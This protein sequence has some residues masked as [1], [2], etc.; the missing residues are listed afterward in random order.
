M[1]FR[2][3]A[4]DTELKKKK[5]KASQRRKPAFWYSE[6]P[7]FCCVFKKG[8]GRRDK[9]R[10]GGGVPPPLT[11]PGSTAKTTLPAGWTAL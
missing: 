11:H 10:V 4:E 3:F 7:R 9:A 8:S 5:K 6:N 1:S 2:Q